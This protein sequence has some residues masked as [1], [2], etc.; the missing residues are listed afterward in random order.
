MQLAVAYL[1]GELERLRRRGRQRGGRLDGHGVLDQVRDAVLLQPELTLGQTAHVSVSPR[2]QQARVPA[3]V[4]AEMTSDCA[5]QHCE[6]TD[7]DENVLRG[8][9]FEGA[10]EVDPVGTKIAQTNGVCAN[11]QA[12]SSEESCQPLVLRGRRYGELEISS[13]FSELH[14]TDKVT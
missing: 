2:Q 5:A 10:A 1:F 4:T 6:E 11:T 7:K 12:L 9:R 13:S 14:G 8:G 3:Q